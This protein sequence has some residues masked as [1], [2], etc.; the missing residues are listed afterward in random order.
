[1]NESDYF[2][3]CFFKGVIIKSKF[4]KVFY[5]KYR[6][7]EIKYILNNNI[8]KK[9]NDMIFLFCNDI[10]TFLSFYKTNIKLIL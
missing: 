6:K 7:D 9:R 4:Y 5:G 8:R 2:V 3:F 10:K 1:M